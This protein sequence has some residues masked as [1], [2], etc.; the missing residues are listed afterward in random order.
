MTL[1]KLL[2]SYPEA[3]LTMVGP[4]KGTLD[5]TKELVKKYHLEK[6][7]TFT[8]KVPNEELLEY[9]NSHSVYLNTTA[10]ESFG[11][12][13]LEAAACGIPIVSTKVGEIPFLW[14][15]DKEIMMCDAH[16]EDMAK[17]VNI[18]IESKEKAEKLSNSAR[19]KAEMFDWENFVKQKWIK[20]LEDS[21]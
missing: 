17:K 2:E 9:Y 19:K 16:D 14:E 3:T 12:A 6:K 20:L 7:I 8:D 1:K 11:V 4:D 10:Y 13:V 15:E 18:I 5:K 21:K